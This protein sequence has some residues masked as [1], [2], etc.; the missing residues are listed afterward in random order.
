MLMEQLKKKHPRC[1]HF[2]FFP[3]DEIAFLGA[4]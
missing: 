2:C 1:F 4:I 3:F